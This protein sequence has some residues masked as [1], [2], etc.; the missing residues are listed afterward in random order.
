MLPPEIAMTWYVPASCS[1]RSHVVVE[2]G[3]VADDDGRDDR[4][5]IARSTGPTASPMARRAKARAPAIRFVDPACRG[6]STSTSAP[7]FDGPDQS[8]RAAHLRAPVRHRARRRSRYARRGADRTGSRTRAA[9]APLVHQCGAQRADDCDAETPPP[10]DSRRTGRG[11]GARADADP[12]H[13]EVQRHAAGASD[14]RV[15]SQ[16]AFDERERRWRPPSG[17]RAPGLDARRARARGSSIERHP[18]AMDRRACCHAS[19]DE[20]RASA[21]K[22]A[23]TTRDRQRAALGRRETWRRPRRPRRPAG[24][25]RRKS[26]DVG[27]IEPDRTTRKQTDGRNG[28]RQRAH[29]GSC[30]SSVTRSLPRRTRRTRSPSRSKELRDLRVFVTEVVEE[31]VAETARRLDA[32]RRQFLRSSPAARGRRGP[33]RAGRGWR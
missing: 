9:G 11:V 6:P 27:P 14:A 10:T 19:D 23:T 17:R 5:R 13:V 2:A 18:Q 25:T 30:A 8:D 4:R 32:S 1:R 3:A 31:L 21:A 7:L 28:C 26:G 20:Q 15:A 33:A 24:Q 29:V 22:P 12:P 16:R